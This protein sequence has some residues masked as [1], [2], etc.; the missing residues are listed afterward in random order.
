MPD[1]R[2]RRYAQIP[3]MKTTDNWCGDQIRGPGSKCGLFMRNRGIAIQTLMRSGHVVI[4]VDVLPQQSVQVRLAQHNHMIEQLAP[5]R[6]NES[7]DFNGT[8]ESDCGT[9]PCDSH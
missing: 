9:R 4:V 7:L 8:T 1:M 3:V 6:A 2:S 5:Q